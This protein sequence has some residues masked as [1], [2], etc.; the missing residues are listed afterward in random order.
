M[1]AAR[2]DMLVI[3]D[4]D[5]VL[6]DSERLVHRIEMKMIAELGW[7][8]TIEEMLDE[9]LGRAWPMVEANI[10]RH[11]GQPVPPHFNDRRISAT[12]ELFERELAP[13]AG[14]P[15]AVATLI[16]GGYR[17]CVA[18]SSAPW[19]IELVLGITGLLDTFAGRIYSATE[20]PNGKPAPDLFLHAAD[21]MSANPSECVVIED[22][23]AGVAAGRAAGMSVIGYAGLTP[24][25]LLQ[26]AHVVIDD[27][28]RLPATL[29]QFH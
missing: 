11:I 22:S 17:T 20:V 25:R 14:I 7:P 5:G 12:K 2:N 28:G 29:A 1:R 4:C 10:E 24:A 19:R 15:T 18:S 6:V 13:I 26:G 3:F 21:Q 23:P 8:I 9:H 16:E 27:M